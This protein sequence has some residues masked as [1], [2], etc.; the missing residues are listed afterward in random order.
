[1][2]M[3]LFFLKYRYLLPLMSCDETNMQTALWLT[4][5]FEFNELK[6]KPYKCSSFLHRTF[7]V[8]SFKYVSVLNRT[9]FILLEGFRPKSVLFFVFLS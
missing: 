7:V 4:G 1:M 3:N 2:L 5:A 6:E 9:S 8:I